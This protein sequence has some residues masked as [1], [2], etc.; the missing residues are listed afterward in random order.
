MVNLTASLLANHCGF[1]GRHFYSQTTTKK[2]KQNQQ[3][4][5]AIC[6]I[7]LCSSEYCARQHLTV[8]IMLN[9]AKPRA[10]GPV[11]HAYYL[12]CFAHFPYF[13]DFMHNFHNQDPCL[14]QTR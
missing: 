14:T 2:Q 4:A 13:Y 12:I 1:Q 6:A 7:L 11:F 10:T 9:G 5:N 8:V 3:R